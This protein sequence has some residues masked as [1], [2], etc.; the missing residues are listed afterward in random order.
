M[1]SDTT[2]ANLRHLYAQMMGG[3]ILDAAGLRQAAQG[4]LAPAIEQLEREQPRGETWRWST[5]SALGAGLARARDPVTSHAAGASV[6]DIQDHLFG[7]IH[8]WLLPRG[9][10]GGTSFEIADG[11]GIERV[12]ISPRL[13]PMEKLGLVRRT[14]ERRV[15]PSGRYS[16]V[17]VA[18][19]KI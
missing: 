13:K 6:A 17:W 19:K 2:I 10:E 8:N 1:A 18:V 11:T 16:I 12:T 15:G 9:D 3:V 14:D 4:L 7:Q 5:G